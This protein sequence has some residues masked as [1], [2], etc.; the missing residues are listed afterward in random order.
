[1]NLSKDEI[2]FVT[3]AN[4]QFLHLTR[5]CIHTFIKENIWFDGTILLLTH[6]TV[7]FS[8]KSL[9]Q[10]TKIYPKIEIKAISNNPIID[11][12]ISIIQDLTKMLL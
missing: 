7:P 2:I 10:L 3:E 4:D 5:T 1:M 9:A 12:I 8:N 11:Y 6:N